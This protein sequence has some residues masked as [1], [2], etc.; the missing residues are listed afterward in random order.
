VGGMRDEAEIKAT[1]GPT[2]GAMPGKILQ[3][4]KIVTSRDPVFMIDE[5]RQDGLILPGRSL[6]SALLEVL[7]PEQNSAFRDHIPGHPFDI[8]TFFISARPTTLDTVPGP[9]VEPHG[10][11]PAFRL[12]NQEKLEIA[13]TLPGARSLERKRTEEEPGEVH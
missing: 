2:C 10:G 13:P 3:G 5:N 1:G 7:D 9:L 12:H 8:S 6:L 4:L 11:H